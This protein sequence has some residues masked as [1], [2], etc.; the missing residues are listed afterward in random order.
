ML[1][2]TL[3]TVAFVLYSNTNYVHGEKN[4]N[5][6]KAISIENQ[7]IN[8]YIGYGFDLVYANML[9]NANTVKEVGF[10]KSVIY[11]PNVFKDADG[12]IKIKTNNKNI[13]IR[14]NSKCWEFTS[15]TPIT[16]VDDYY[17]E[18]LSDF[19][20]DDSTSITLY[21]ANVDLAKRGFNNFHEG[22]TKIKKLYCSILEA[23]L[24]IPYSGMLSG[25]FMYAVV[26]LPDKL[27]ITY[28]PIDN[29]MENPTKSE[30]ENIN[31]WME[32]FKMYGTH[33]STHIITGGKIFHEYKTLNITEY[34]KKSKFRQSTNIFEVTNINF[35]SA[36]QKSTKNTIVFGGN[37]VKGMESEA[38]HF[39]NEW[40]KTLESRSL[41]IKVT[42]KPLSI[43]MS[44][45]NDI[46][47]EALKFYRDVALLTTVGIQYS[48]KI[49]ELLR[50]STTVVSDDGMAHC[51]TNQIVL[52]GFIMSKNP[53]VPINVH[54]C[55]NGNVT[56]LGFAFR[57]QS[58]SDD[59][60]VYCT[61]GI[62]QHMEMIID[63][64]PK[65]DSRTVSC[66]TGWTILKGIHF[67][68]RIIVAYRFQA[69]VFEEGGYYSSGKL[70]QIEYALNGVANGAPTL[71]IKAANGVVIA[72]E[73][74]KTS[75]LVE[76]DTIY[77]I[78]MFAKHIGVVAAGIPAD[79]RVVLKKGRKEAIRYKSEYGEDIPGS[80]LVKSVAS[81]IQEYTHSGGVRPF[82]ISL[83][84]ASYDDEGP[85]L[86]QIDPSGAY[87]GWKA[88]AIG[89]RMQ[90]NNTFL[91][92]RY[93]PEM[94]LEDAIH[95][96]IL[97]LKEGFEGELTADSIEIG[98]VGQ[99]KK[100]RILP[101]ETINDYLN[102]VL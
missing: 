23:G 100:F 1:N 80:Q 40:S 55:P 82:G 17:K 86:Y 8:T 32:F 14:Q 35:D 77:K 9:N 90:N 48:T 63:S 11:Q 46:Y 24:M 45:R 31:R 12:V 70:V 69:H 71:G 21:N 5:D 97:T 26:S 20:T 98:V 13:W 10:R 38:R 65:D 27:D 60:T 47:K 57:K 29:Y 25:D 58:E 4:E 16:S 56:A 22:Y 2:R 18:L 72:A 78:D 6:K 95:V 61:K 3:I 94:D 91:E 92:K 93:N 88:T 37:Y 51:P 73:R 68:E 59:W 75:T 67:L 15:K 43:F 34:R 30:C 81:I 89:Q 19:N 62:M 54:I 64:A 7:N 42:V 28:C 33:V 44:Y 85:Q 87:F 76:K 36:G 96:A 102:E 74:V 66:K 79:F 52:A 41:P 53:K 50:E 39:Y 99:D 84:L 101:P 83:L 49:D